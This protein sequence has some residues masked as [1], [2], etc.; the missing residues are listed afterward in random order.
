M[1]AES[2]EETAEGEVED[3]PKTYQFRAFLLFIH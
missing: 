1:R 3:I 2:E